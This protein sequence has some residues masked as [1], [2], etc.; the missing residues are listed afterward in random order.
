MSFTLNIV[1][2]IVELSKYITLKNHFGN[3]VEIANINNKKFFDF[4]DINTM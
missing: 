4:F 3:I 2:T 1:F